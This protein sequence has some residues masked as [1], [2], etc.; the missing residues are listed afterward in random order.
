MAAVARRHH[1]VE[2]IDAARDRLAEDRP[3]CRRPSD[4]AA[5]RPAAPASF[6]KRFSASRPGARQ[7]QGRR[8]RSRGNRYRPARARS[9]SA[10]PDRRRP[11]RCRTERGR[12]AAPSKARLQRSAQRSDSFMARSM[13]PRSAGSRTHSS[14]CMTMSEPSRSCTSTARSGDNSTS[15]P[16]ICERKVTPSSVD[17]P[18]RRERHHLKAAGIGQ[19]RV[20]PVHECMQPAK[21]GDALR[22]RPQHQMIG[23]AEQNLGARGAHVIVMHALDRGLRADRHEGRRV[24]R[25]H[26]AVVIS[27]ARAAPSVAARRKENGSDML[28]TMH[29]TTGRRRHR[30]R[31]GSR[32]RS[33]AHKHAASSQVHKKRTPA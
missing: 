20:R 29:E 10:A 2:H 6:R 27:P 5:G 17:L 28:P 26:A 31:T 25:R 18:Q 15:A 32:F 8:W 9:P 11:A 33:H 3:A 12:G 22:R 13:S 24:H 16:S 7:P 19:D 4:S 21:R 30:S 1:A 23:V 14:S